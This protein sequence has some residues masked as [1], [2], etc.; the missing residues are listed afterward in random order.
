L[1]TTNWKSI[2]ELI[3]MTA[4]VLSLLFVGLQLKQAQQLAS[5]DLVNYANERQNAIRELIVAN[6]DVWRKACEGEPLDPVSRILAAKILDA[7]LDHVSGE[8]GLRAYGVRQSEAARDKIVE[9]IAAQFWIYPG[10]RALSDSR[11]DWHNGAVVTSSNSTFD[12]GGRVRERLAELEA[13]GVNP[14]RD[15]AWC[16]RT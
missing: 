16:G 8:Y 4:I 9:E 14:E 15:V 2:A 3:G 7:W 5:E 10:L 1:R 12:L 6:P 11:A 13:S